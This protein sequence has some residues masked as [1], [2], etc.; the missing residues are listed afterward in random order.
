MTAAFC[1]FNLAFYSLLVVFFMA[2]EPTEP[3]LSS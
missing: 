1:Y 2:Q 3:T